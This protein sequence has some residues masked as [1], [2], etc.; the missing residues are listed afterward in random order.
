VL[1]SGIMLADDSVYFYPST[2][3][4]NVLSLDY[5]KV[6]AHE[7]EGIRLIL[8]HHRVSVYS[9]LNAIRRGMKLLPESFSFIVTEQLVCTA[10]LI[11][12]YH[13]VE[14]MHA[15]LK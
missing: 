11:N 9:T 14:R 3:P 13:H 10:L 5:M 6:F 4:S 7:F 2:A 8:C 15:L 1:F 12:D